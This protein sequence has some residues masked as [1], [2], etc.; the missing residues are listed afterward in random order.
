[1]YLLRRIWKCKP[2]EARRVASLVQRQA[3]LYQDTGTGA[4]SGYISTASHSLEPATVV[5]EWT[6][7][8]LMSP[9]RNGMQRPGRPTR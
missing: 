9:Y 7:D 2:G 5:L 6:D 1:M 4:S 3:Q 8:A